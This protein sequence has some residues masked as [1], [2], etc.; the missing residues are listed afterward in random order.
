MRAFRAVYNRATREHP[1]LPANPIINVDWNPEHRRTGRIPEAGLKAWYEGVLASRNPVRRDY[2]LFALFTGLRKTNAAEVRWEDVDWERRALHVPKPKSQK[3]FDLPLSDF[4]L[5]LLKAR[6]EENK[7][8][9]PGSPWVFPAAHG[10][11]H[12][13]ETRAK[14]DAGVNRY[15]PHDL[16][17]T[18]ISVAESL[19]I[20][21]EARQLLVNHATPKTDVHGGY[22]VPELDRL[23]AATQQIAARLLALCAPPTDTTVVPLRKRSKGAR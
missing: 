22:V 21:R 17:R 6:L 14:G 13:V 20:S 5:D 3:A 23:R 18:F 8:L 1:E 10:K 7:K 4:L 11:G 19:G 2:L 12:I 15:T 9:A 16:R